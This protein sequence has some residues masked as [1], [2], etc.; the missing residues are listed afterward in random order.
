MLQALIYL[1]LMIT[2]GL[3]TFAF[4]IFALVTLRLII[5]I[6]F[7]VNNKNFRTLKEARA[8]EDGGKRS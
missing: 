4:D 3:L 1:P 7:M 6:I 2:L 8:G 5:F